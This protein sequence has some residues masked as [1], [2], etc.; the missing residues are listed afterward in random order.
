MLA[1]ARPGGAS[2]VTQ[3]ANPLKVLI[4]WGDYPINS[5]L[6]GLPVQLAQ[7]GAHDR[8]YFFLAKIIHRILIR[9]FRNKKSL[10]ENVSE[11]G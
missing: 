10:H 5:K 6:S 4:F 3:D 11:I 1:F 7:C 2:G 9:S 8:E